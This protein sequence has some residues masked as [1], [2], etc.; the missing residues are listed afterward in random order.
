MHKCAFKLLQVALVE[1]EGDNRGEPEDHQETEAEEQT[2][3]QDYGM[4]ELPLF[5]ISG[6]SQPQ[7][8]K[9][10][11]K[12]Q[13]AVAIIMIDSGASHNFVS[14]KLIEKLGVRVEEEAQFGVCLG[15]GTK[16]QCQGICKNNNHRPLV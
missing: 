11:G 7:T 1:E 14:R 15:D 5:S 2:R 16:V 9:L 13:N 6:M 4:V 3:V 12:V 8:M 10:R